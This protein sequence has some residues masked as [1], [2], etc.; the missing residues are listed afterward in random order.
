MAAEN[1]SSGIKN[2]DCYS[3]PVIIGPRW[4]QWLFFE[5]FMESNNWHN[6]AQQRVRQRRHA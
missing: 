1:L 4:T 5:E 6:A 2:F 3:E